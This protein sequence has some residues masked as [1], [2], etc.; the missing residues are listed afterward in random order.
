MKPI[1]GWPGYLAS[2][3]GEI[4]STKTWRG[5][6]FRKLAT[7][8]DK[9]DYVMVQLSPGFGTVTKRCCVHKLVAAAFLATR[10]SSKHEL[11]HLD[12]DKDN[13]AVSNLRWGTRK[14]NA[15]DRARHGHTARG[16]KQGAS[17]LTET[18]V[19]EIRRRLAGGARQ[20]DVANDFGLCQATVSEIHRKEIWAWL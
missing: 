9:D 11:R 1:P 16:T 7:T 4:Y 19:L 17:K 20:K 18:L 10:P 13:N 14:D 12:G 6:S 15:D 5:S 8:T 2:R 3:A